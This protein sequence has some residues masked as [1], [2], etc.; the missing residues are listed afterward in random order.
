MLG[1]TRKHRTKEWN[2]GDELSENDDSKRSI[3]WRAAAK[4]A[5]GDIPST[6]LNL[7]GLRNREGQFHQKSK[8]F[9]TNIKFTLKLE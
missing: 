5:F 9:C 8:T 4:E 3:D 6:A 7:H 2:S 1:Q